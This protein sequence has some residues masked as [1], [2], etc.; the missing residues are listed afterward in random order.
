[1][2]EKTQSKKPGHRTATR[3]IQPFYEA[4]SGTWTY[5]LAD[6]EEQQA[7]IIDP[8]W[9]YNPVT[10]RPDTGFI[11]T[12]LKE[13]QAKDY[14]ISWVLETHAHADHLSAADY[15]RTKT[16]AKIAIGRGIC[17]VQKNFAR[18]FNL[19]D[20]ST[21]GSQ[22][23]RLLSEGD[24]ITLGGLTIEVLE[25]PGHTHDSLSF[26]VGDAVFVGDTL[27]RPGYGTARCDFPGG[28]AGQ[29]YDSIQKIYSLRDV[30]RVYLCHDYPEQ[31]EPPVAMV[32]MQE[33]RN[34]NCHVTTDTS[35]QAFIELRKERDRTLPMPRLLLPSIQVN[36]RAGAPPPADS[37]GASYL[38]IPFDTPIAKLLP[39]GQ[40]TR[41]SG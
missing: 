8:V 40:S 26:V 10:G 29:L 18:V 15:I 31:D 4:E 24:R 7:A 36:I 2:N 6:P 32:P 28:D 16:G 22:F 21:D 1:M 38:R 35:R 13:A 19:S 41:S 25:T 11:D 12:V 20:F 5:L 33:S 17:S 3:E 39:E 37:N 14:T 27:F 34:S 23:D 30:T 9:V